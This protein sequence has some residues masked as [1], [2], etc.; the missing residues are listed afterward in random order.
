MKKYGLQLRVPASQQKKQGGRPPLPPPAGF[1]DDDDD[2]DAER[3]VSRPAIKNRAMKEVSRFALICF[4]LKIDALAC[5]E[6]DFS[7]QSSI[8]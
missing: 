3:A 2:E 5:R 4:S 6:S 7:I 1:R 8:G